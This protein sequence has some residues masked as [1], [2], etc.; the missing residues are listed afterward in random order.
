MVTNEESREHM[1]EKFSQLTAHTLRCIDLRIAL[2]HNV[3]ASKIS[4]IYVEVQ[5]SIG[6]SIADEDD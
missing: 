3:P 4:L 5:G 1:F 6:F 2:L